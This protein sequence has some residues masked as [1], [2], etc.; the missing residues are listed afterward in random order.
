VVDASI[1]A[2]QVALL[3]LIG[4]SVIGVFHTLSRGN[5]EQ[6]VPGKTTPNDEELEWGSGDARASSVHADTTPAFMTTNSSATLSFSTR[7]EHRSGAQL[8]VLKSVQSYDGELKRPLAR[9]TR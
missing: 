3:E 1:V 5:T 4:K 9:G 6:V 7:L 2:S 8:L